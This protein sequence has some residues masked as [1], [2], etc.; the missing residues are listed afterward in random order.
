PGPIDHESNDTILTALKQQIAPF[1][2]PPQ[3]ARVVEAE[4]DFAP[5]THAFMEGE[6]ARADVRPD[7]ADI[8]SGF[9]APILALQAIALELGLPQ[10]KVKAHVVPSGGG[11]GRRV[12]FDAPMEAA[13]ISRAAGMPVRLM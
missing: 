12:F 13:Q 3:G 7:G 6:C 5:V 11:F 10:E 2:P 9:Q 1:D 8:W 4:F